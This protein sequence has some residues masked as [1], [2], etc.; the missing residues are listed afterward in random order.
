M[1]SITIIGNIG[2]N[3][4]LRTTSDGRQI[5]TF[6]VAV[7][8]GEN[9]PPIWFGCVSNYREKLM[10]YLIKGQCVCIIGDLQPRVYNG[11]LDL[12]ISVDRC[13]LC[14]AKPEQSSQQPTQ[15]PTQQ[16]QPAAQVE[17]FDAAQ[18]QML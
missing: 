5:M 8:V 18:Q 13:E 11:A 15:E 16:P 14:G 7:N 2:A 17:S 1:K 3:A 10:P 12:S 6:N 4:V 9:T